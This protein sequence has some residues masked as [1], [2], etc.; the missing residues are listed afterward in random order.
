MLKH[1]KIIL[2][3][4]LICGLNNELHH[5]NNKFITYFFI[6]QLYEEIYENGNNLQNEKSIIMHKQ[7]FVVKSYQK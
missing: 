1:L 5:C 3:T 7:T 6:M 4:N 2:S